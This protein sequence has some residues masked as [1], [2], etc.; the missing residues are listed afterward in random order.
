MSDEWK[1]AIADAL[2]NHFLLINSDETPRAALR[3]L[4]MAEQNIALDPVVSEAAASLVQQAREAALKEAVA[5]AR[6]WKC[7][8]CQKWFN[9]DT[10]C[11]CGRPDWEKQGEADEISA[12]IIESINNA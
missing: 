9:S 6:Q 5:I 2:L 10:N 12:R 11:N 4:I 8:N 1:D 7:R 3:R